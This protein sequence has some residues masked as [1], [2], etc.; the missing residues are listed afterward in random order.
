MGDFMALM[1]VAVGLWGAIVFGAAMGAFI[2][3][4]R[5]DLEKQESWKEELALRKQALELLRRP[6]INVMITDGRNEPPR[7]QQPEPDRRPAL[8]GPI[9]ANSR[10]Y[11]DLY[12]RL[13]EADRALRGASNTAPTRPDPNRTQDGTRR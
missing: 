1:M 12:W 4:L 13:L 3:S 5:N 9:W 10:I 8:L 7:Q 2:R 6:D 11:E